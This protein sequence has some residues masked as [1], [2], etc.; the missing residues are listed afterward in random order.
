MLDFDNR[1]VEDRSFRRH[2][3]SGPFSPMMAC[4]DMVRAPRMHAQRLASNP[5]GRGGRAKRREKEQYPSSS[6]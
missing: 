1:Y 5:E 6:C 3:C 2:S 4:H